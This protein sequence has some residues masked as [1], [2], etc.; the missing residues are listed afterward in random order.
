MITPYHS[1]YFPS[2]YLNSHYFDCNI[3]KEKFLK[4]FESQQTSSTFLWI[5]IGFRRSWGSIKVIR[6][7]R[8]TRTKDIWKKKLKKT[9]HF[10]K[11]KLEMTHPHQHFLT[12]MVCYPREK[13][14]LG[15]LLLPGTI[16]SMGTGGGGQCCFFDCFFISNCFKKRTVSPKMLSLIFPSPQ[17]TFWSPDKKILVKNEKSRSTKLRS[18]GVVNRK[19]AIFQGFHNFKI[20]FSVIINYQNQCALTFSPIKT[21]WGVVRWY[22]L[23]LRVG[24]ILKKYLGTYYDFLVALENFLQ[25]SDASH[26]FHKSLFFSCIFELLITEN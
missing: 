21:A 5:H 20:R 2:N 14:T 26:F 23:L 22:R 16:T 6:T 9:Q 1:N 11:K 19:I 17:R 24:M 7:D 10:S 15:R 3:E 18:G 8:N 25:H 12:H 4:I 13:K